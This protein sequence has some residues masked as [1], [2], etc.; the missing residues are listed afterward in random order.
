MVKEAISKYTAL[1]VL[2]VV[3][4]ASYLR[5]LRAGW[6]PGWDTAQV[7]SGALEL[8][9]SDGAEGCCEERHGILAVVTALETR[10]GES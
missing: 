10:D 5:G 9:V 2:H 7:C 6:D 8:G 3:G 1:E 4:P